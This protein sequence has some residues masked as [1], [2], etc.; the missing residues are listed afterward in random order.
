MGYNLYP[1]IEVNS[2]AG[3]ID[4]LGFEWIFSDFSCNI[5]VRL[6]DAE[7]RMGFVSEFHNV[8]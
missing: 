8:E 4:L 6:W 7:P 2:G 1:K 3:R 5:R